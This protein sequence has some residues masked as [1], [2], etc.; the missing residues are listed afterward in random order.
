MLR[1]PLYECNKPEAPIF[2]Q[3]PSHQ[4]AHLLPWLLWLPPAPASGATYFSTPQQ[5]LPS[6]TVPLKIP[7]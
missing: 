3:P 7:V 6:L 2:S 4:L 5:Q 1:K